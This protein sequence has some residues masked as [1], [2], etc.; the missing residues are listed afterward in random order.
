[1]PKRKP[2]APSE[3]PPQQPTLR[4]LR[5]YRNRLKLMVEITELQ[6][7]LGITEAPTGCVS[8]MHMKPKGN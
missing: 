8:E 2:Q 4:E 1:M 5:K 3:P 6:L 7:A